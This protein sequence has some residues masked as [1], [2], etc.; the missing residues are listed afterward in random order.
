MREEVVFDADN[1]EHRRH[2]LNFLKNNTWSACP[3]R[4]TTLEPTENVLAVIERQMLAR[5]VE[6][7]FHQHSAE[8]LPLTKSARKA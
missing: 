3:V 8:V 1:S 2:Y 4:F 5:Y 6:Q 7:E